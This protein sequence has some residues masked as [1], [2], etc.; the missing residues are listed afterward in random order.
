M[1]PYM[2]FGEALEA[3]NDGAFVAR[4]GWNGKGMFLYKVE[5]SDVTYN[6]LRGR[7]KNAIDYA[8]KQVKDDESQI[9]QKTVHINAHIDMKAAD[10]SIIV[11]WS[12]TQTD[13]QANDW[14]FV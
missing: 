7:C 13:M 14:Y 10:G 6:R 3:L 8:Y 4:E 1:N 2:T 9:V 11:G 12:A 5:A